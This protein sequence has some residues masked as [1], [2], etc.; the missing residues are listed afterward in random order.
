MCTSS[1]VR[2]FVQKRE[3]ACRFWQEDKIQ[4]R[5]A[6]LWMPDLNN[7]AEGKVSRKIELEQKCK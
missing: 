4:E 7:K 6:I 5:N 3:R 1:L 2:H